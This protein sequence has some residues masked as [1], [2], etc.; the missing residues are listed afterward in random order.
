MRKSRN[1]SLAYRL[2]L[3]RTG[4]TLYYLASIDESDEL[5][6]LHTFE[7][8]PDDVTKIHLAAQTGGSPTGIDMIW[9]D[10]QIEADAVLGLAEEGG[11]RGE[12]ESGGA[13]EEADR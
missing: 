13:G 7:F 1:L 10:L 6:E 12:Q 8:P 9:H 2:G 11:R 5:V 3:R 4:T